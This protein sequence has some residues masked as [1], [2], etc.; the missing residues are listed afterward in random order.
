MESGRGAGRA[1]RRLSLPCGVPAGSLEPALGSQEAMTPLLL[2]GLGHLLLPPLLRGP[3]LCCWGQVGA[4]APGFFGSTQETIVLDR[5]PHPKPQGPAGGLKA[6]TGVLG[7]RRDSHLP[8]C[9]G[10]GG[11][12]PCKPHL[13]PPPPTP[14]LEGSSFRATPGPRPDLEA[15]PLPPPRPGS[16]GAPPEVTAR[17]ADRAHL[18][19][20]VHSTRKQGSEEGRSGPGGGGERRG[21]KRRRRAG[22]EGGRPHAAPQMSV[23]TTKVFSKWRMALQFLAPRLLMRLR[24]ALRRSR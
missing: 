23:S 12:H 15:P 21:R 20:G 22:R 14:S 6:L 18:G 19:K 17:N 2:P 3:H 7:R 5:H 16:A 10:G 24:V 4:L 8:L 13:S 9:S 11:S 1:R